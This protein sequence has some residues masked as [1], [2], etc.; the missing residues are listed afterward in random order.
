VVLRTVLR[1]AL[2]EALG[3]ALR[4]ALKEVL[5]EALREALS[6][7]LRE[8]SVIKT[9]L[10]KHLILAFLYIDYGKLTTYTRFFKAYFIIA[11]ITL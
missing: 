8:A 4:E 11:A 2:R 6:K 9:L 1:N 7:A 3:E 5:K 10:L